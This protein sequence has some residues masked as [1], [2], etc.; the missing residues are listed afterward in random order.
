MSRLLTVRRMKRVDTFA[1]PVI[2]IEVV[3]NDNDHCGSPKKQQYVLSVMSTYDKHTQS[4]T[5][6]QRTKDTSTQTVVLF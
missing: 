6:P 3:M 5:K 4:S 1:S 2:V